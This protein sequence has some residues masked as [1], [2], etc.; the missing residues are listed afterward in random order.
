[1]SA[2]YPY[3]PDRPKKM[4]NT[5]KLFDA[6]LAELEEPEPTLAPKKFA[7]RR[8]KFR[9]S[10]VCT[11]TQTTEV[12]PMVQEHVT[13]QESTPQIIRQIIPEVVQIT[14]ESP[15][16]TPETVQITETQ[17]QPQITPQ[18]AQIKP[19]IQVQP[20]SEDSHHSR[21]RAQIVLIEQNPQDSPQTQDTSQN[22]E[23]L[24]WQT[25]SLSTW[26]RVIIYILVSVLLV[27]SVM[28][29][30][31][32]GSSNQNGLYLGEPTFVQTSYSALART[33][34]PLL[35]TTSP[36]AFRLFIFPSTLPS[37]ALGMN[38]VFLRIFVR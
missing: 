32:R 24:L 4:V 21:A 25:P 38:R 14:P 13:P 28:Q 34:S 29:F 26:V 16:I 31:S 6:F 2:L 35:V 8:I 20:Q 5:N 33:S 11:V 36:L 10:K 7:P 22:S 23:L 30:G 27:W 1:M 12:A 37:N 17:V 15:Q 19:E 9:R 3:H 18:S